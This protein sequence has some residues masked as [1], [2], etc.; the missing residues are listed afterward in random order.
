MLEAFAHF[1]LNGIINPNV[2]ILQILM[3][4]VTWVCAVFLLF[5]FFQL[6]VLLFL[7]DLE[8][9]FINP[10]TFCQKLNRWMFPE[11]YVTFAAS[12]LLM[13]CFDW[14]GFLV[15]MVPLIVI[16]VQRIRNNAVK[17]DSSN[18]FIHFGASKKST[19][20]RMVMYLLLFFFILYRIMSSLLV[21]IIP[22][23]IMDQ[24]RS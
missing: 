19:I 9:D 10:I 7:S 4:C 17:F 24:L 21:R 16:Q 12:V 11:V 1:P 18:I 15:L 6:G 22:H 23:D 14:L 3:Y 2:T 8:Q 5:F 13:L 20:I